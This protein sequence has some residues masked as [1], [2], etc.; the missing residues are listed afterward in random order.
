MLNIQAIVV[1]GNP[2]EHFGEGSDND[3]DPLLDDVSEEESKEVEPTD[4]LLNVTWLQGL[5]EDHAWINREVRIWFQD[6]KKYYLGKILSYDK[7]L[8]EFEVMWGNHQKEFVSLTEC[9]RCSDC[10]RVFAYNPDRWSF[11]DSPH[12]IQK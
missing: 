9:N 12:N 10:T 5:P 4:D 8:D 11:V 1:E 6:M 7:Q 2:A 3:E